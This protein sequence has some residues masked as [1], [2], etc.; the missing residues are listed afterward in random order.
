ME[1]GWEGELASALFDKLMGAVLARIESK[2]LNHEG[3]EGTRRNQ[4][5]ISSLCV[6]EE[7]SKKKIKRFSAD[8]ILKLQGK[9][10]PQARDVHP[11]L[12]EKI[13]SYRIAASERPIRSMVKGHDESTR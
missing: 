9:S 12:T 7:T 2:S 5:S 10:F 3:H 13:H 6:N 4:P 1:L 11:T 8:K